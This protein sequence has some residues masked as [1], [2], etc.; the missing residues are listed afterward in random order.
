MKKNFIVVLSA[1]A[2]FA[3]CNRVSED[4]YKKLQSE[5]DSIAKATEVRDSSINQF[6][7]AF[8]EIERTL[9]DI[10]DKEKIVNISSPS[11][12]S[13]SQKDQIQ[14]DILDMYERIKYYKKKMGKMQRQFKA[15]NIKIGQMKK[16]ITRLEL[17]IKEKDAEIEALRTKLTS[18]N[19]VADSLFKNIDILTSKNEE[20]VQVIVEKTNKLNR[21]Y[22]VIG[23]KKE[24]IEKGI[25]DKKGMFG[26]VEMKND[27]NKEYFTAIDI[28]KTT[29]IPVFS[30]KAQLISVH[31]S[32]S[33]TMHIAGN[34][35]DSV[36]ITDA[37]EFWSVSKYCVI[38]V[39]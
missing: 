17:E 35:I 34:Q 5:R 37:E 15:M 9:V 2:L 31:P 39:E 24:L 18:M 7:L 8:N 4:Q 1:V 13:Q 38:I 30:P 33:Y 25:L 32:K 26:K 22:F 6:L 10:K 29:G 16:M 3:A 12:L 28:S 36:K 14:R 23:S 20:Q 19:I 11:E 21:A 27:L